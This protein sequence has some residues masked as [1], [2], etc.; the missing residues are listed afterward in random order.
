M[1]L[2]YVAAIICKLC[3]SISWAIQAKKRAVPVSITIPA[4]LIWAA[5]KASYVERV[6]SRIYGKTEPPALETAIKRSFTVSAWAGT[7]EQRQLKG[8]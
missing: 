4:L 3:I 5:L 1:D 6:L 2:G 8:V 7:T